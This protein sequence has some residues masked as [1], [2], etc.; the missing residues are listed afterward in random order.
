[1]TMHCS[2]FIFTTRAPPVAPNVL[3]TRSD[4]LLHWTGSFFFFLPLGISAIFVMIRSKT[5]LLRF[6]SSFAT[7]TS[8]VYYST[9]QSSNSYFSILFFYF[10]H[11]PLNSSLTLEGTGQ[12]YTCFESVVYKLDTSIGKRR[13]KR[14][15]MSNKINN[16][17]LKQAQ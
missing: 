8:L 13:G 1:M 6:I 15:C 9:R 11:P 3:L 17:F 10:L 2:F 7:I 5:H 14:A 16:L 4:D 12:F